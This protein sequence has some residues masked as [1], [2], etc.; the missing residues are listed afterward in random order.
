MHVHIRASARVYPE[1]DEPGSESGLVLLSATYLQP[2]LVDLIRDVLDAL[3][4]PFGVRERRGRV[5]VALV[6]MPA[7]AA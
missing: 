1:L 2:K 4:E 3:R 7:Y 6:G 5:L